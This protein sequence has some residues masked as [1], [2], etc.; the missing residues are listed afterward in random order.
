M[1]TPNHFPVTNG[2]KQGCA[3]APALFSMMF[4]AMLSDAFQDCDDG[5][6]TRYR[7]HGK[8][9][10]LRGLQAKS[11]VQ[12][13]VIDEPLC[14]D[15]MAKNREENTRSHGSFERRHEKTCL[16]GLRPG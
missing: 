14:A 2:V 13:D 10:N 15:D 9:F 4:S 16:R 12:T 5:F 1:N 11:K 8:L 7:F 3:L 6:P